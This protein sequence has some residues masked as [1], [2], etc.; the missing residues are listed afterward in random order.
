[1]TVRNA[2]LF[3]RL[4]QVFPEVRVMN[5]GDA[6]VVVH[7]P[8]WDEPCPRLK[9]DISIWGESYP[10]NCPFCNDTRHRLL[11]S[12]KWAVSDPVTGDDN[13]HLCKCFNESCTNTRKRQQQLHAMVFPVGKWAQLEPPP[14]PPAPPEPSP[15]A[16]VDLPNGTP[17]QQL[18]AGHAARRYLE[19]RGFDPD[20]LSR[21][22]G[23]QFCPGDM[24]SRPAL[25][26]WRIVI[27]VYMP[28]KSVLNPTKTPDL[29]GWM[30]RALEDLSDN[31]PKYLTMAGM[32]KSETL[33]GLPLAVKTKGP[34][35]V[36]EGPADVWKVGNN[37]VAIIGKTISAA[38]CA[39]L[40]R[41][42]PGRPVIVWLD[43]DA[44]EDA[45]VVRD[46]IRAA[47]L[48]AG[49]GRVL[50]AHCPP[51]RKDPGEC[52]PNEIQRTLR[53]ASPSA[54]GGVGK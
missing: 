21:E 51:G 6:M 26:E 46:A 23:L 20:A 27:P 3:N 32:R 19:G 53:R 25:Y 47:G 10:V 33:Y 7:R 50:L 1:M 13:L 2:M 37:A 41:H 28:A 39:L 43:S 42:F 38:Q 16:F 18:K 4:R 30:A 11:I 9:A 31:R 34:V 36:V 54:G 17:L 5:Q 14:E 29:V 40:H 22:R 15:P 8:E 44:E 35:V 45:A 24:E 12:H 52:T 48:A 49:V